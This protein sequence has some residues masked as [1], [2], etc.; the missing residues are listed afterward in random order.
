MLG[1]GSCASHPVPDAET[2]PPPPER[3]L[4]PSY[5]E[6]APGTG[7]VTVKRDAGW[8]A[9]ICSMHLLVDTQPVADLRTSER[10]VLHLPPGEHVLSVKGGASCWLG[11]AL[12]ETQVTV[13]PERPVSVR[14]SVNESGEILIAP[15][16]F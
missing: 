11:S 4:V 2:H 15:T 1:V 10:V 3:I 9:G 14:L 16:K 7:V 6:A 8:K 13:A 5:L 12:V